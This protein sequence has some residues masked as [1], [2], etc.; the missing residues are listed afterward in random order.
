MLFLLRNKQIKQMI[1]ELNLKK[2]TYVKINNFVI[3]FN[4][5]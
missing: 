2:P 4:K 1:N 5:N 3:M